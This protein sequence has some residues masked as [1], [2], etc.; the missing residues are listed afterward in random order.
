MCEMNGLNYKFCRERRDCCGLEFL[1]VIVMIE[2]GC[3]GR[4]YIVKL[5]EKWIIF[6]IGK[7]RNIKE[8]VGILESL[9]QFIYRGRR[10]LGGIVREVGDGR[11]VEGF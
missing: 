1:Q 11:I 8:D 2:M 9:E 4:E 3:V 6:K 5:R 10:F 7:V